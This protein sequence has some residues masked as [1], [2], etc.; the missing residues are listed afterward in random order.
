[1]SG[2]PKFKGLSCS[3]ITIPNGLKQHPHPAAIIHSAAAMV[4]KK[5]RLASQITDYRSL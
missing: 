3:F 4:I 5:K 2:N 1:M